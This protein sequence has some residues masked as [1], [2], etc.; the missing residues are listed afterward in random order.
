MRCQ[1]GNRKPVEIGFS[2]PE[3]C[4]ELR[5]EDGKPSCYGFTHF[6]EDKISIIINAL[7][8]KSSFPFTL[9]HELGHV[10]HDDLDM[11]YWLDEIIIGGSEAALTSLLIQVG[12]VL[13]PIPG[14]VDRLR[15]RAQ[16]R[17]KGRR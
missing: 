14:G 1:T 8:P 10:A 12:L 3:H 13:P 9:I 17:R 4:R 11:P 15:E 16:K 5:G 6:T 7:K 2:T